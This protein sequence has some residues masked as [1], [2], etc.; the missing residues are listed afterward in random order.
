MR[1]I[2]IYPKNKKKKGRISPSLSRLGLKHYTAVII[3]GKEDDVE[4]FEKVVKRND[5]KLI[6]ANADEKK[7]IAYLRIKMNY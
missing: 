7:S 6:I 4:A 1:A 3:E 2:L 5:G